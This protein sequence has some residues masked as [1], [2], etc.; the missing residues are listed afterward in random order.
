MSI[1]KLLSGVPRVVNIG[2]SGFAEDLAS[3]GTPVV[4]V[5]WRP[6]AQGKKHLVDLLARLASLDRRIAKANEEAL[7][8][9]LAAN[10]VL[11]DVQPAG[12]VIQGLGERI[13][14]HSGPPISW[15]RMCGPMQGAV[16]GAI[17]FEGWAADLDSATKLAASGG[18]RAIRA[19]LNQRPYH[20]RVLCDSPR[21]LA[22]AVVGLKSV[23]AVHAYRESAV[24]HAVRRA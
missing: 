18:F 14:L 16:A 21:K 11:I 20:V 3:Q 2:L 6:P 24:A 13:L 1:Q 15:E 12:K 10:P 5:D 8:R 4:Q 17:V 19:A 22:A 7:K 23:D 9:M